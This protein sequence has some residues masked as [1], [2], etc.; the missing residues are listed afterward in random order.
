MEEMKSMSGAAGTVGEQKPPRVPATVDG[1]RDDELYEVKEVA[2]FFGRDEK[3]IR[4]LV[5]KRRLQR[6]HGLGRRVLFLGSEIK[7]FVRMMRG[8]E[9]GHA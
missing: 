7:R 4:K 1:F 5:E 2:S 8:E 6:A 9:A 3:F